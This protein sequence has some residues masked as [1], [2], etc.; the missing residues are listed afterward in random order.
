[1][2]TPRCVTSLGGPKPPKLPGACLNGLWYGW[3]RA[4][5]GPIDEPREWRGN[6]DPLK[7]PEEIHRS[8]GFTRRVKHSSFPFH[9]PGSLHRKRREKS[10]RLFTSLRRG[11]QDRN[12]ETTNGFLTH[13]SWADGIHQEDEVGENNG[14]RE[15]S[16]TELEPLVAIKGGLLLPRKKQPTSRTRPSIVKR[17]EIYSSHPSPPPFVFFLR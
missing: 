13:M 7:K 2:P 11:Q 15:G 10:R 9:C 16:M 5:T 1:M 6:G 8:K 3:L 14:K 4:F 12:L 17:L